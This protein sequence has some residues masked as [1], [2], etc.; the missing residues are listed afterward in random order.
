MTGFC[1][2]RLNELGNLVHKF[3]YLVVYSV[4][5]KAIIVSLRCLQLYLQTFLVSLDT[6]L[7]TLPTFLLH[8]QCSLLSLQTILVTLNHS[9]LNPK[10]SQLCLRTCLATSKPSQLSVMFR[11]LYLKCSPLNLNTS[12][13]SPFKKA[14]INQQTED[15]ETL[16]SNWNICSSIRQRGRTVA[17]TRG[18]Q[19]TMQLEKLSLDLANRTYFSEDNRQTE[20]FN[21]M[22]SNWNNCSSIR[23]RGRTVARCG[24][25]ITKVF[26][27]VLADGRN[28]AIVLSFSSS[29]GRPNNMGQ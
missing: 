23:Q 1:F 4:Q 12:P 22:G 26:R 28:S 7:L 11:L 10:H 15:Y 13:K 16:G 20:H 2:Q 18:R 19:N 27:K 8:L 5:S 29:F 21:I 17:K 25:P 6:F 14:E 24:M 3:D 9:Q